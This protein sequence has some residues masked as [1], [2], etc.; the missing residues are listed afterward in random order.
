[1]GS[2]VPHLL[3]D[4]LNKILDPLR[5]IPAC[6]KVN[7]KVHARDR[8]LTSYKSVKEGKGKGSE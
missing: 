1:V 3:G 6:L 4:I 2:D 7:F 8:R 5:L